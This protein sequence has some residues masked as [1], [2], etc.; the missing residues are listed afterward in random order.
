MNL[1]ILFGWMG[2]VVA[3]FFNCG[4]AWSSIIIGIGLI[5]GYFL[6]IE[7]RID[8]IRETIKRLD[9][10]YENLEKKIELVSHWSK[11]NSRILLDFTGLEQHKSKKGENN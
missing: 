5:I 4:I 7:I 11:I 9:R 3:I 10:E 6:V 8:A 1:K 2:A